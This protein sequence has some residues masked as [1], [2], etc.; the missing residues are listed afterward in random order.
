MGK[1]F[2]IRTSQFVEFGVRHK[3]DGCLI[4]AY[5]L[6]EGKSWYCA[7]IIDVSRTFHKLIPMV[8]KCKKLNM[9]LNKTKT[10]MP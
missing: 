2:V 8:Q 10:P 7:N 4:L 9:E 5:C 1:Y 6:P 3:P